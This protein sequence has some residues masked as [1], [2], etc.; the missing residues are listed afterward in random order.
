MIG[1][2]LGGLRES[3]VIIQVRKSGSRVQGPHLLSRFVLSLVSSKAVFRDVTQRSPQ[4]GG[5]GK[6]CMTSRKTAAKE[7]TRSPSCRDVE[8]F[9]IVLFLNRLWSD[10]LLFECMNTLQNATLVT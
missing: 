7:I 3:S 6:R 10:C 5:R 1:N 8:L 9:E 4:E 2:S